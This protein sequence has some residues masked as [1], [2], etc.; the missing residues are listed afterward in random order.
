MKSWPHYFSCDEEKDKMKKW[1]EEVEVREKR[2]V[3]EK[4]RVCQSLL[5]LA[6][7]LFAQHGTVATRAKARH[8]R[9][10]SC[11][12]EVKCGNK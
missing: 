11:N 7:D 6:I 12:C 8:L 3:G 2:R 10:V 1:N 5:S 4:R 9:F